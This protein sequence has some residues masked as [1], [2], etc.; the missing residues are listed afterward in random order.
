MQRPLNLGTTM[1]LAAIAFTF[2]GCGGG[3]PQS[4][5]GSSSGARSI[6]NAGPA[7]EIA[8]QR[9]EEVG[10]RTLWKN[11]TGG[12]IHQAW[13]EG[14]NIY[15]VRT[16]TDTAFLLEKLDGETGLSVW[17]YPLRE[18]LDARPTVYRYPV[19]LRAVRPDELYFVQEDELV[20]LDDRYG[21]KNFSIQLDFPVSTSPVADQENVFVGSWNRRFYALNKQTRLEQW[22]YITDDSITSAPAVGEGNVYFG[23]ED[24]NVYSMTRGGGYIPGR[25]WRQKTGSPVTVSPLIYGGRVFVGSQDYKIYCLED[26]GAEAYVRWSFPSGAP[27]VESPFAFREWVFAISQ[28]SRAGG[29]FRWKLHSI[30]VERGDGRWEAEGL[31][32][33]LA[34]DAIH[35]YALDLGGNIQALRL[36]SG[37]VDWTLDTAD[38]E[39]VLGQNARNGADKTW[40]GRM[41]L[42]DAS[43]LVQ[44]IRPRR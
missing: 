21:A 29:E 42:V 9:L 18:K 32:R 14:G 44:A 16:G 26:A 37:S 35:C 22:S 19:E 25:S 28:E 6:E 33:V 39:M 11:P 34:A 4:R 40:W 36:E 20:G 2:V 10:F 43:G 17:V 3:S 5:S 23:S 38:F 30:G 15:V 27:I 7:A 24:H 8:E 13:C 31:R 1:V 12:P 41:F